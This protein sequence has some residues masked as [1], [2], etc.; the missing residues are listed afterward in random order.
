[1]QQLTCKMI[2]SFSFYSLIKRPKIFK[3]SPGGKLLKKC[4]KVWKKTVEKRP[5]RI[6]PELSRLDLARRS[7]ERFIP[8]S[9]EL[10]LE[11]GTPSVVA[12]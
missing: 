2:W 3:K 7:L 5:A 10:T 1:M 9:C 8:P 12:L 6:R 11:S 4:E